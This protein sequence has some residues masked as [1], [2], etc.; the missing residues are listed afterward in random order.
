MKTLTLLVAALFVFTPPPAPAQ[1]GVPDLGH[2]ASDLAE[3]VVSEY[4]TFDCAEAREPSA[5]YQWVKR[6]D[7]LREIDEALNPKA[8]TYQR[9]PSNACDGHT[10]DRLKDISEGLTAL[11]AGFTDE[12]RKQRALFVLE[13]LGRPFGAVHC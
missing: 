7:E 13:K 5:C 9:P 8:T 3:L 10:E 6:L 4:G 11:A 12:G 2:Y 1:S